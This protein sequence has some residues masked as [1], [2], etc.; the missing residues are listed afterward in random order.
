MAEDILKD[1][2]NECGCTMEIGTVINDNDCVFECELTGD[3]SSVEG[4]FGRYVEEAKKVCES[5]V[6]TSEDLESDGILT[7]KVRI[8]FSCTAENIIFQLR[9]K[10]L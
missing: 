5:A 8:E 10:S 3:R 1:C 4:T 6:V 9:A 2:G 7:K